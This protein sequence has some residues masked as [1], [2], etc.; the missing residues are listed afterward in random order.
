[1]LAHL[2]H[3]PRWSSTASTHYGYTYY[4]QVVEYRQ[5]LRSHQ[6]RVLW[7]SEEGN[8]THNAEESWERWEVLDTPGLRE[9]AT[10]LRERATCQ[11]R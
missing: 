9:A 5:Y 10:Q 6:W 7:R 2:L 11:D 1:M 8:P 3:A 4:G